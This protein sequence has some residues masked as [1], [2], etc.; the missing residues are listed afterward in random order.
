MPHPDGVDGPHVP[1]VP[2]DRGNSLET[3]GGNSR[4]NASALQGAGQVIPGAS[5]ITAVIQ[6]ITTNAAGRPVITFKLQKNT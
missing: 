5:R 6:G 4:T 1:V 3:A 2:K